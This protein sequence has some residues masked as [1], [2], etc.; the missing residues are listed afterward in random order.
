MLGNFSL[1]FKVPEAI[2]KAL[3]M[4]FPNVPLPVPL[5][6]PLNQMFLLNCLGYLVLLGLFW[7]AMRRRPG[8][9][10][11][12]DLALIVYT[13]MAFLAWGARRQWARSTAADQL[14]TTF[15]P[16]R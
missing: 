8:L 9:R 6:L 16:L 7:F 12:V 15:G 3:G 13:A 4:T 10:L 2:C 1:P 11:W 5:P 14:A